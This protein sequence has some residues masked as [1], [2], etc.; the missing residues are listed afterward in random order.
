[1]KVASL[2]F[3]I[4]QPKKTFNMSFVFVNPSK[5]YLKSKKNSVQII[6]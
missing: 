2:L 5:N 1:M 4:M 3:V 6:G